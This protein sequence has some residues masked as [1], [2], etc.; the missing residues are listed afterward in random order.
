MV[1]YRGLGTPPPLYTLSPEPERA[2]FSPTLSPSGSCLQRRQGNG[3]NSG[4]EV[5]WNWAER[6]LSSPELGASDF[7]SWGLRFCPCEMVI[8]PTDV[9]E[10]KGS[11][12]S[13]IGQELPS[14]TGLLLECDL[15]VFSLF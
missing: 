14:Q 11:L 13:G 8:K 1:S 3:G 9:W 12:G 15:F 7:A 2:L 10:D 6:W 5:Q 4:S